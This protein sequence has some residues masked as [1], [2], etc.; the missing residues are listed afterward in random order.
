MV[1]PTIHV[2]GKEGIV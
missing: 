1:V 2:I